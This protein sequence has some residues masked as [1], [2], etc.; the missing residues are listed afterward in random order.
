M[1]LRYREILAE[2]SEAECDDIRRRPEGIS[3]CH[4]GGATI[5][6]CANIAAESFDVTRIEAAKPPYPSRWHHNEGVF[7]VLFI[8]LIASRFRRPLAMPIARS[9]IR[10]SITPG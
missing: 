8:A 10:L 2:K 6:T 9:G 4:Q 7:L 5:I 1:E 3:T